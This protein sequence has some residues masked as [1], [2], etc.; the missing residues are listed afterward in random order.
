MITPDMAIR[1]GR[2]FGGDAKRWLELQNDYDLAQLPR[3]QIE[4]EITPLV[5]PEAEGN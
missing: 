5:K 2:F 1:L 4:R 3:E